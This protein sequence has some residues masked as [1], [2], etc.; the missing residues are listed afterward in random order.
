MS[1]IK[2]SPVTGEYQIGCE[3][4]RIHGTMESERVD[5]ATIDFLRKVKRIRH[6]KKKNEGKR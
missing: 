2:N 5:Q 6:S 1:D 4:V 3:K